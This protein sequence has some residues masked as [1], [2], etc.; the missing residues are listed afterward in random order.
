MIDF[1]KLSNEHRAAWNEI[2]SIQNSK[3]DAASKIKRI[4]HLFD[5]ELLPHFRDEEENV[6]TDDAMSQEI[7]AE[8]HR[9]YDLIDSMR[10]GKSGDAEVQEFIS[11]L[12]AHIKKEDKYFGT[13][14]R[15]KKSDGILVKFAIATVVVV[16]LIIVFYP[17]IKGE[18]A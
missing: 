12:K 16:A 1:D 15:A 7:L 13:I 4:M 18:L 9:I 3:E 6:L 17:F 5:A 11:I 10:A 14:E 8:H 2:V